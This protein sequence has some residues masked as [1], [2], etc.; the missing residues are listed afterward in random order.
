MRCILFV[1][2]RK[3]PKR[4]RRYLPG[5]MAKVDSS[6]GLVPTVLVGMGIPV[7][8]SPIFQPA[9]LTHVGNSILEGEGSWQTKDSFFLS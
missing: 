1:L 4:S 5:L 7:R 3:E 6:F 9:G 2:T 8:L